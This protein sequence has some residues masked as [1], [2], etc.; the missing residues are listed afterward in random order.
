MLHRALVAAAFIAA[1]AFGGA[2]ASAS[3]LYTTVTV[4]SGTAP[5]RRALGFV[6][7]FRDILVKV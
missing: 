7:C 1:V 3:D 5:E 4:T 2:T 6:N